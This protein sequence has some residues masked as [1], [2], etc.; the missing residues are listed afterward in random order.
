MARVI[1]GYE[2][3]RPVFR[4][5]GPARAH[6]GALGGIGSLGIPDR[7]L[8]GGDGGN[9]GAGTIERRQASDAEREAWRVR[10]DR[11]QRLV[12]G[13]LPRPAFLGATADRVASAHKGGAANR[14]RLEAAKPHHPWVS[15]D[16]VIAARVTEPDPSPPPREELIV[17]APVVPPP[18][19]PAGG[20]SLPCRT[21]VK[22]DVCRIRPML[23]QSLSEGDDALPPGVRIAAITCDFFLELSI[24][25]RQ[26]PVLDVVAPPTSP[27][28][29][30]PSARGEEVRVSRATGGGRPKLPTDRETR[31]PLVL[32]AVRETSTTALAGER[33]GVSAARIQQVVAEIR[34]A[35]A[36]PK[37]IDELLR[38]RKSG[39]PVAATA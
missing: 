17:I 36:L 3:G 1:T 34:H 2:G 27:A 6:G 37:D 4:D 7:L 22:E 15:S 12:V 31:D 29:P 39:R 19:D 38:A 14:A 11:E 23:A 8:V 20:V 28:A 35:G 24:D 18:A 10:G 21:C 25:G 33:L 30:E 13:A 9:A 5:D 26:R 32:A 16:S